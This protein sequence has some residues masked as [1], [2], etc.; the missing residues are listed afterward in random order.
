MSTYLEHQNE[1]NTILNSVRADIFNAIID[2]PAFVPDEATAN[3][4]TLDKS[5]SYTENEVTINISVFTIGNDD[6]VVLTQDDARSPSYTTL[7]ISQL[8]E[9]FQ[10]FSNVTTKVAKIVNYSF[11]VRVIVDSDATTDEITLTAYKKI[12][13]QI[14]LVDPVSSIED[15][16]ANPYNADDVGVVY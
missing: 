13:Q 3:S 5:V 2:D 11:P 12:Y 1:L 15:D 9:I 16:L 8:L 4:G 7:E 14:N 10:G 6:D